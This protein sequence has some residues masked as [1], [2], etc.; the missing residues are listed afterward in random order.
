[1]FDLFKHLLHSTSMKQ[2]S[3][4]LWVCA[5]ICGLSLIISACVVETAIKDT[6]CPSAAVLWI[7]CQCLC[8]HGPSLSLL[9]PARSLSSI[10]KAQ[11]L[12][13]HIILRIKLSTSGVDCAPFSPLSNQANG[14]CRYLID[15]S[16]CVASAEMS[17]FWTGQ[18]PQF[19]VTPPPHDKNWDPWGFWFPRV[20]FFPPFLLFFFCGLFYKSFNPLLWSVTFQRL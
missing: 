9:P 4:Q 15:L 5:V 12:L 2:S 14:A 19:R 13:S 17:R 7:T 10:Y 3:F 6:L 18:A 8:S 16:Q 1:M 11:Q 20:Y